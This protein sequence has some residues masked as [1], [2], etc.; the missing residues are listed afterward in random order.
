MCLVAPRYVGSSW[1][2][3]QT[4]VPCVGRQ[5]LNHCATR[6]V[7]GLLLFGGFFFFLAMLHGM[8]DLSSPTRDQTLALPAVQAWSPNH[9]TAR[10]FPDPFY[11]CNVPSF[12]FDSSY[13]NLFFFLCLAKDLSILL[14][15]LKKQL[16]VLLI[17][18]CCLSLL[19]FAS[20]CSDLYYF[21]PF[22]SFGFS[23][24]FF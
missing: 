2:R 11:F 8:W 7:P 19:Y 17:F 4:R 18:L 3:A 13:S 14:I 21:F 12:I 22:A 24:F 16:L 5:I 6:E 1:T 15:F 9:W 23:L 10:E 20:L